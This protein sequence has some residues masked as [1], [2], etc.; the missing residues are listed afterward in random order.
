MAS[1]KL[2]ALSAVSGSLTSDSLVYIADTQDSGS[3]YDSKKISIANLLSDVASTSDLG[4]FT[5]STINNNQSI[6][7]ALQELE[8]SLE[9]KAPDDDLTTLEVTVSNLGGGVTS[10]TFT[11]DNGTTA[12]PASK[13]IRYNNTTPANVTEIYISKTNKAGVDLSNVIP[14]MLFA[15]VRV[16]LQNE[17]DASQYL[18][19]TVTSVSEVND[20]YTLSVNEVNAGSLIG[21]N[22]KTAFAVIGKTPLDLGT[23]TGSIIGDSATPKEALQALETA[24]ETETS[25]R[26]IAISDLVDGAPAL[27]DTL[28]ELA[29]AIN[30]DENFV[31]TITN[32]I[33]A[34]E[35]HIDNVATL[36]GVAKDSANLGT[37]TGS[38]IADSSTLKAAI[39]AIE[40][41]VETKATSTVV[42]EIDANVDDLISLSGVA[43]QQT[44]LGTFTGSTISDG[45]N[46]KDALQDLE[47]AAEAAAAGSA[48][49]DRTKTETGDADTSHYLT[50]V[51]D[52]NST[53][54]AE[55][56]YTDGGIT[57]NP[58]SNLLSVGTVDPTNLKIGG[59]TVTAT[60]SELNTLNGITAFTSEL[61]I[62]DG[63]TV[64]TA[65]LNILDG[66]TSTAA[67][68]NILDGVTATAVELNYVDG[69]TSNVQTQ[70]DSKVATGANVNTLVGTTSAQ[71][72]PVDGNGDDNYL[73]LVV[74]KA[75]GA[76][77]AVDKTFLEAEG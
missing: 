50:F 30:D 39:Q 12:E 25:N 56:V 9:T 40:T 7:A 5:G 46:I 31:S 18:A 64:T 77:T 20:T 52:D 76:L 2:S 8:T 67:E 47:T 27:L 57:Y 43:E 70:I 11:F 55:T 14:E 32:L 13:D 69:V 72:V 28:N 63:A 48:V 36:T 41:A 65:E 26:A 53:A 61:N 44:G 60:A 21:N 42:S 34:N 74:N 66:V 19:A 71:T 62:L 38:T 22:K 37:F 17:D 33:D 51:A 6:K 16:Y 49:A 15:G 10:T 24:L 73:F 23:F 35:T 68:L 29:A 4:T 45:A 75:T 3:S 59:V 58:S 1:N 54:T